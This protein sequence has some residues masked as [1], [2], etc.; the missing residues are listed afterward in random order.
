MKVA[1]TPAQRTDSEN[2][3]LPRIDL[4]FGIVFIRYSLS[5]EFRFPCFISEPRSVSRVELV[6]KD[7]RKVGRISVHQTGHPPI[8]ELPRGDFASAPSDL[9]E[10]PACDDSCSKPLRFLQQRAV[11]REI[12]P[13]PPQRPAETANE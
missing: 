12:H 11:R 5:F 13:F 1:T 7:V 2:A 4:D 10:P 3:R 8:K 9:L 6:K